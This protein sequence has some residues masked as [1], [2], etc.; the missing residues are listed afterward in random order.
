MECVQFIDLFDLFIIITFPYFRLAC[1]W[2]YARE[3]IQ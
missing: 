1:H 3:C 2:N